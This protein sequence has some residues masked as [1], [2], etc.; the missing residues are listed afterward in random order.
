MCINF[1]LGDP[2]THP[3]D[4][5][6]LT[7]FKNWGDYPFN[8][9]CYGKRIRMICV[10]GIGDLPMLRNQRHLFANKFYLDYEPFA[11]DCMEELHYN[12][13]RLDISGQRSYDISYYR[14]LSF[15]NNHVL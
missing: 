9:P 7:R 2:E 10:F 6:Y 15:V 14:Q 11:Y 4:K 12:R 5:P 1:V 8:W 3:I 13:T